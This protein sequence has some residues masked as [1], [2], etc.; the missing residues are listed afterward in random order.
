MRT[1]KLKN[2]IYFPS[3]VVDKGDAIDVKPERADVLIQ[4]GLV[5]IAW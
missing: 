5:E 3:F 2:V 4:K 1:L